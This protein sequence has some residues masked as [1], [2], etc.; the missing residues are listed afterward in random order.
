MDGV[1]HVEA[2]YPAGVQYIITTG[3]SHYIGSINETTVLKYPHSKDDSFALDVER[4]IFEQLGKNNRIIEFKGM[5]ENGLLLEYASNGSLESYVQKADTTEEQ[6][7]RFA[8]ETAEG[9]AYDHGKNIIICD[10]NVRNILLDAELHVKLYSASVKTDIFALGSTI[11]HI[12]T[13]HRPFPEL[14]TIDDEAE[15]LHR[16]KDGRFP[17]LEAEL[18]GKVIRK[19]WEGGYNS[20]TEIVDDLVS[21]EARL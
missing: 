10:I 5:H 1:I 20:A 21:L 2:Y 11:Y 8:R 7:M 4:K 18:G 17:P 9:V 14:D 13:G 12:V 16:Y 19:C 6:K 15:F 3:G